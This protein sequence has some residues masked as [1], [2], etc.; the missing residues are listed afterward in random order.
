MPLLPTQE[1]PNSEK[2]EGGIKGGGEEEGVTLITRPKNKEEG[3]W[4]CQA[5]R[6]PERE[7]AHKH[8]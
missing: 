3:S 4:V 5:W 2:R 1:R 7:V 8:F 6:M